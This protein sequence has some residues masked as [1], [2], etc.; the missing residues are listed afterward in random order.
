M[1]PSHHFSIYNVADITGKTFFFA[2][3]LQNICKGFEVSSTVPMD[4]NIF[5]DEF[6]SSFVSGRL[7]VEQSTTPNNSKISLELMLM[8]Y[9]NQSQN[10]MNQNIMALLVNC[11]TY[12]D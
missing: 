9:L 11:P 2:F 6:L 3:N 8:E 10:I 5:T 12:P 1:H 4:E 7:H